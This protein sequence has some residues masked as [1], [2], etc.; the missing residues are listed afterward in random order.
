MWDT[1]FIHKVYNHVN[2]FNH[3]LIGSRMGLHIF[4]NFIIF[5]R[6]IN[7]CV[8]ITQN[9]IKKL[10]KFEQFEDVKFCYVYLC[11]TSHPCF[12]ILCLLRGMN[13]INNGFICRLS[14]GIAIT[15]A[16]EHVSYL[17]LFRCG[18]V[19]NIKADLRGVREEFLFC[20]INCTPLSLGGVEW[21]YSTEFVKPFL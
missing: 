4:I 11:R 17:L 3:S 20:A 15:W 19:K 14:D 21:Q 6:T 12:T 1:S 13:Y 18:I 10:P 8:C 5:K 16:R 2:F 9:N 7:F